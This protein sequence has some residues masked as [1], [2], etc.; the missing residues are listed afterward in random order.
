MKP[1]DFTLT[2]MASGEEMNMKKTFGSY[3]FQPNP[4]FVLK[5]AE[6]KVEALRQEEAAA[7]SVNIY[8]EPE[9][10]ETI[11]YEK[12][13]DR[14]Y[15][16]LQQIEAATFNKLVERLTSCLA[17]GMCRRFSGRVDS[18]TGMTMCESHEMGQI[19]S[20]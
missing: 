9:S 17:P 16:D 12:S 13:S 3:S 1:K 20:T 4:T 18:G 6:E 10:E 8:D 7:M 2:E 19:C 15:G 5:I 14:S 11:R